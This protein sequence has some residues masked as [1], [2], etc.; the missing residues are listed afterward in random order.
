M[1]GINSRLHRPLSVLLAT[2]TL[3]TAG[4]IPALAQPVVDPT[5]AEF[6]PSADHNATTPDGTQWVT[7]Y[8]LQFFPVGTSTPSHSIEMGKPA[9][10]S[11]GLIRFEFASKLASPL[12]P[13]TIYEAR[14]SAVGPGGSA[15]SDVS[16]S[17]TSSPVCAPTLSATSISIAATASTGS[18]AIVAA[19]GC[20]WSAS[21]GDGWLTV[22]AGSS[23]AGS[24]TVSFSASANTTPAV[25]V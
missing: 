23:G 6:Q 15:A 11:D 3:A 9:P 25:R 12:V 24:G 16:N 20:P 17:F 8:V 5:I 1:T 10:E 18:V 7:S 13:G 2:V 19:S 22:T 14:V 4:A 21:A